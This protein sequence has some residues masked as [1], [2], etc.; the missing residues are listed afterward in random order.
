MLLVDDEPVVRR[1]VGRALERAGYE[2]HVASTAQEALELLVA[3]PPIAAVVSDIMMDDVH[4]PAL[5]RQLRTLR[6]HLPAVFMS[7]ETPELLGAGELP[8]STLFVPK[9]FEPETLLLA[10]TQVL[11]P[12]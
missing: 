11:L 6:P 2:V 9:P 1:T 3:H 10:L 4:G 8:E 12:A 7:G 5:V